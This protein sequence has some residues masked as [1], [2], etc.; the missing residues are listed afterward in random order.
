MYRTLGALAIALCATAGCSNSEPTLPAHQPL[1]VVGARDVGAVDRDEVIELVIALTMR[2]PEGLRQL[3]SLQN[4]PGSSMYRHYLTPREFGDQFGPSLAEYQQ[5]VDWALAYN[6]EVTRQEPSRTTMS[7]RGKAVDVEH[8]FGTSLRQWQDSRGTFRAPSAS[9]NVAPGLGLLFGGVLGLDDAQLWHSHRVPV[10]PASPQAGTGSRVP[11]DLQTMYN[12]DQITQRGEGE[13]VGI[14]GTGFPPDPKLDVDGFI[15]HK[16]FAGT[17]ISLATAFGTSRTQQYT[18]I[19]LGGPNRDP[20]SF[21]N[22]EY[23]ENVLDID[24]VLGIAP[25]TSVVHVLTATNGGGLFFDGIT[26]FINNVP[27]AHAVTVS[28]GLCERYIASE[29]LLLNNQFT[30]AKAQGQTWFFAAGDNGTNDCDDGSGNKVLTVEWPASSPDAVGVG[31]TQLSGGVEVAWTGGGGGQSEINV[32][33]AY[34]IGVGP[35]PNDGVRD[36]PD[37]SA[38]AGNPG[39]SIFLQGQIG[40]LEGTSAASPMVAALWVLLDQ[41][42]GGGGQTNFHERM[43]QLGQAN[44]TAFH[45]IT[46]GANSDGTTPGYP[47]GPGYDLA[48][49]WGTININQLIQQW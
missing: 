17:G 29:I 43:Y 39:I 35:F 30:Q 47:A 28:F 10:P 46:T 45:D 42:K 34:Q 5:V 14:L 13:T 4:D 41:A 22:D 2:E 19:F 1:R 32:K 26:Y 48:T 38:I 8:A 49:G 31:G 37:I 23:Q 9:L 7:V 44:S 36:V 3:I 27:N 6:L 18:Q 16:G 33:P 40:L 15:N 20:A 12:V 24:C 25:R 11:S 21:A